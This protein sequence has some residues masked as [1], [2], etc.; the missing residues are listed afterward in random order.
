MKQVTI[1]MGEVRT[2]ILFLFEVCGQLAYTASSPEHYTVDP[3]P[4]DMFITIIQLATLCRVDLR[5]AVL[6]KL[7]LNR[8]KYPVELVRAGNK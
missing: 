7:E 6:A 2:K 1:R 4:N 5:L 3:K 8:K